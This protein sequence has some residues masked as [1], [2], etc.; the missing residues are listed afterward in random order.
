[1]FWGDMVVFR[2]RHWVRRRGCLGRGSGPFGVPAIAA[3]CLASCG[4]R[5]GRWNRNL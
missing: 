1:M 2:A 3:A 4:G 5:S